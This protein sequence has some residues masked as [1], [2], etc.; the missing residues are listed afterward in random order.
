MTTI[1]KLK[2][3]IFFEHSKSNKNCLELILKTRG[4]NIQYEGNNALATHN[5]SQININL[6]DFNL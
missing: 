2:P 4:Y 1:E 3:T 5:E 6:S